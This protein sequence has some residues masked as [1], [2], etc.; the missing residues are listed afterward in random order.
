M[1]SQSILLPGCSG[2]DRICLSVDFLWEGF[3][4][5]ALLGAKSVA[6]EAPPT[7]ARMLNA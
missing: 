3:S 4:R 6:A 1:A 5:N 2:A 7:K